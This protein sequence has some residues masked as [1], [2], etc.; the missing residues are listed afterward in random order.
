M[1]RIREDIENNILGVE[2][3]KE[4]SDLVQEAPWVFPTN[5]PG[6]DWPERGEVEFSNFGL[7]YREGLD[8]VIRDI[9]VTVGQKEDLSCE[10]KLL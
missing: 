3:I 2:R 7:R 4:Y 9:N 1:L 10:G 6:R 5:R 8:L